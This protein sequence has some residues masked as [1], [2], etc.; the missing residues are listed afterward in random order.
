MTKI[1]QRK[2]ILRK[3]LKS[4]IELYVVTK[5]DIWFLT[6]D[7]PFFLVINSMERNPFQS[8]INGLS[9]F[10][11]KC[12]TFFP[13]TSLKNHKSKTKFAFFA[14]IKQCKKPLF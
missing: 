11:Q 9:I 13:N 7:F 1:I 14:H 5:L 8:N 12:R 10:Y 6:N 4:S 3:C 2:T